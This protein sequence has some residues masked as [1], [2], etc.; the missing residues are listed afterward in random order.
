MRT[1]VKGSGDGSAHAHNSRKVFDDDGK[2]ATKNN[3]L[4]E[5]PRG[6]MPEKYACA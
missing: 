6:L 5:F 3:D 4:R 2:I 1:G